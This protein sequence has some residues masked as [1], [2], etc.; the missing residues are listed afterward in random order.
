MFF[1]KSKNKHLLQTIFENISG[2]IHNCLT[3]G[4]SRYGLEIT[5][6]YSEVNNFLFYVFLDSEEFSEYSYNMV[7]KNSYFTIEIAPL[8]A[9]IKQAQDSDIVISIDNNLKF[10]ISQTI[11]NTILAFSYPIDIEYDVPYNIS[12]YDYD[13]EI[14]IHTKRLL[15][16]ASKD[17]LEITSNNGIVTFNNGVDLPYICD[18]I[19]RQFRVKNTSGDIRIVKK[20]NDYQL[21]RTANGTVTIK[22]PIVEKFKSILELVSTVQFNVMLNSH[23]R[24]DILLDSNIGT[25][26]NIFMEIE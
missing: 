26:A 14:D 9:F 25:I 17:W 21:L 7:A 24:I 13:I 8:L 3:I 19:E 18:G 4:I 23:I 2:H 22:S 20:R 6:E 16:L 5:T 1:A 12:F 10:T 11:S 15:S